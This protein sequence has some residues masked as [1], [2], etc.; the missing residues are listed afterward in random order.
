MA[1]G[2][3]GPAAHRRAVAELEAGL[4]PFEDPAWR[5]DLA[6]LSHSVRAGALLMARDCEAIVCL[7]ERV[8]RSPGDER[9]GTPWT[10]FV[11]EVAVAKKISDQAAH[12][13]VELSQRLLACHPVALAA[14]HAGRVPAQRARLLVE[15]CAR[16]DDRVAAVADRLLT[17][18]LGN[19]PPWR[20]RQEVTL[21]ALRLDPEGAARREAVATAGREA[22]LTA[23][24][25]AQSEVVLT[26]PAP[27]VQLAGG[28]P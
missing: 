7:A 5:D 3:A 25:D 2:T 20:I 22:R 12:A 16:Y 10:S 13:E 24:P 8:P 15:E 26:G 9:G 23:L 27:L 28:T 14:L 18:Q 6:L 19:L 4:G 11:R 17:D 21:L 1:D